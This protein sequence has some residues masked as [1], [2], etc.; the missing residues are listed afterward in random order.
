MNTLAFRTLGASAVLVVG[1]AGC[2][3]P[4]AETAAKSTGDSSSAAAKP[5][6][7]TPTPTSAKTYSGEE[8]AAMIGQLK[9][10]KGAK[11]AVMSSADLSGSVAQ[12]K[13]LLSSMTVE[14]AECQEMA[15]SGTAPSIEGA[16]AAMGTSLDAAAG[17]ST[18]VSMTSGLDPAFLAKTMA[19]A[20]EVTKCGKMSFTVA[21]VKADATLTPIDGVGSVPGTLGYQT[22]TIM[23]TGQK[24]SI[25]TAQAV[26]HGVLLTVIAMG[27]TSKE[28]A[29][30]RTG[31]MLDQAASLL[32]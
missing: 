27:G 25:I 23:S 13:S 14:P 17:A 22:D 7:P 4:A 5:A 18:S 12:A 30:A 15:L 21:G 3:G 6:T 1:L 2:G 10:A 24:Q 29:V 26:S 31:A 16:T 28:E 9:D 32:K 19:Q 20:G 11:L 8:L